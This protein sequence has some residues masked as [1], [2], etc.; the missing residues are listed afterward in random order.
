MKSVVP[1]EENSFGLIQ[2]IFRVFQY[3]SSANRVFLKIE[4]ATPADAEI[5][6]DNISITPFEP[7]CDNNLVMNGD[8]ASG[9]SDFWD[10]YGTVRLSIVDGVDSTSALKSSNRGNRGW[11]QKQ[12]MKADCFL[13]GDR[14][15]IRAMVKHDIG[16]ETSQ[17]NPFSTRK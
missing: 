17:C 7:S 9:S 10:R 15:A 16:D 11:G 6:L 4:R 8:F 1:Y 2:G 14:I 12:T 5:V 3:L 13:E